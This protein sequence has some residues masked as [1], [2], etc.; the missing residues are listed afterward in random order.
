MNRNIL[1]HLLDS[2]EGH[3]TGLWT[4]VTTHPGPHQLDVAPSNLPSV[5][6]LLCSLSVHLSLS[7]SVCRSAA[8]RTRVLNLREVFDKRLQRDGNCSGGALPRMRARAIL[9]VTFMAV[10]CFWC[11]CSVGRSS[12]P[13]VCQCHIRMQRGRQ[14]GKGPPDQRRRAKPSSFIR[15]RLCATVAYGTIAA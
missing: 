12:A 6:P 14:E 7:L 3:C 15:R 1:T 4:P 10:G 11:V 5:K 2:K 9:S 13:L 8:Q